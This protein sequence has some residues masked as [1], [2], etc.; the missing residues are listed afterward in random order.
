MPIEDAAD[1]RRDQECARI[2]AGRRLHEREQQG[3]IA[4]DLLALERFGGPDAFE[5]RRDLDE[6]AI[7][8]DAARL[9]SRNDAAGLV[10][11]RPG[12]EGQIGIRFDRDTARDDF[13]K[14]RAE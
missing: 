8:R 3:E 10:D 6:D 1:E 13:C 14:L 11:G 12:I 7:A 4:V 2:G 5:G 9:A